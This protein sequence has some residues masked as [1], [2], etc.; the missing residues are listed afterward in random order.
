MR[1]AQSIFST[2]AAAFPIL[3][4]EATAAPAHAATLDAFFR[5]AD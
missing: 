1:G 5:L 4:G 3:A 2:L